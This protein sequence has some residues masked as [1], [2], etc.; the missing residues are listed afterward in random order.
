MKPQRLRHTSKERL[1]ISRLREM[2]SPR[3][4]RATMTHLSFTR[5]EERSEEGKGLVPQQEVDDAQAH[6]LVAEAQMAAARPGCRQPNRKKR[7]AKR[8]R[9]G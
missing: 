8:K 4:S 3:G 9:R 7:G 5:I 2:R 6:D 1:R